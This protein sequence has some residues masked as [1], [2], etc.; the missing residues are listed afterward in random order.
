MPLIQIKNSEARQVVWPNGKL[1]CL[2][3]QDLSNRVYLGTDEGFDAAGQDVEIVEPLGFPIHD[4]R[5]ERWGRTPSG[6]AQIQAAL[7]AVASGP[8]PSQIAAQ[9]ALQGINVNVSVNGFILADPPS[10]DLT[11]ATD[12]VHLNT[13]IARINAAPAGAR[14]L[15]LPGLYYISAPLNPVTN[16]ATLIEGSGWSQGFDT[17]GA[18]IG[19]G[20]AWTD[21]GPMFTSTGDGVILL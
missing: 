21:T 12:L 17:F 16:N 9:I 6:A 14:A 20:T 1:Q 7:G 4:G 10:G 18:V 8:S 19:A 15:I 13:W 5:Q 2:T 11:G 3:N